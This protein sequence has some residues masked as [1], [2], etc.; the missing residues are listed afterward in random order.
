MCG[1]DHCKSLIVKDGITLV[2]SGTGGEPY[3]E[4]NVTLGSMTDCELGAYKFRCCY[5]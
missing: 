5:T 1:H 3:D 2:V 4:P